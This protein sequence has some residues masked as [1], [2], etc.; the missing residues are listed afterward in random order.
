MAV[1]E[2]VAED[3]EAAVE[4]GHAEGFARPPAACPGRGDG[5]RRTASCSGSATPGSSTLGR[6][7]GRG[8]PRSAFREARPSGRRGAGDRWR[9]AWRRIAAPTLGLPTLR[10]AQ[11]VCGHPTSEGRPQSKGQ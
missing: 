8:A 5:A 11:N 9:R 4:A 2:G 7:S 1:L 10:P 6:A 3:S